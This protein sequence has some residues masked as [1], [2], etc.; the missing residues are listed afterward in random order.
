MLTNYVIEM[1]KIDNPV[2]GYAEH[3]FLDIKKAESKVSQMKKDFGYKPD[4]LEVKGHG[5]HFF[6]VVEPYDLKPLRR[7]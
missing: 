5:K 6:A 4:I 1:G 2:G 3:R 7:K